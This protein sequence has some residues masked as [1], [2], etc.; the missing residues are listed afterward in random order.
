LV[1]S[2]G[3]P[4]VAARLR[5]GIIAGMRVAALHDIR[6]NSVA[7]RVVLAELEREGVD[8]IVVGGDV[9]PGPL[10]TQT[11]E[12]L[13]SLQDRAVLV[14]G[15]TDR[16]VVEAFDARGGLGFDA[17]RVRRPAADWTASM[18]DRERRDFLASVEERFVI[19]ID[20]ARRCLPWIAPIRWRDAHC[21]DA[22]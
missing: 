11:I 15:I 18:I 21:F 4:P 3:R 2:C 14:R 1:L 10:P 7:L 12:L 20:M 6:G 17:Q 13:R 16:R 5:V 22:G 8:L 9:V 19:D